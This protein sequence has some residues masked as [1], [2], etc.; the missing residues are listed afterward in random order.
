MNTRAV[1]AL[2]ALLAVAVMQGI[3][4]IPSLPVF[5]DQDFDRDGLTNERE[6]TLG[7]NPFK[8]DTDGDGVG[9]WLEVST[10]G[11]SPTRADTDGD[12]FSDSV[13][14]AGKPP[15]ADADPLQRDVF[16]EIDYMTG[17]KPSRE[18]LDRIA[19]V[20][21]DGPIRNP[22]GTTGIDIHFVIDEE[23]G[24][25]TGTTAED[26]TRIRKEHFDNSS[27]GYH[28]AV[29]ISE[30]GGQNTTR[31]GFQ[32]S[33]P[34]YRQMAIE[35][36]GGDFA[37][38]FMHE[39]GHSLG[40]DAEDYEGVDS[41]AVSANTYRSIMN[42][43]YADTP[44]RLSR[45][46]PFDDWDHINDSQINPTPRGLRSRITESVTELDRSNPDD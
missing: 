37:P 22:D 29:F 12:E 8:P 35:Y 28:Y 33:G 32:S 46:S 27:A 34:Q 11:T 45:G 42:Y 4:P 14:L 31:T 19:A 41:H 18:T 43:N 16:V 38:T 40:I 26:L 9:D 21:A 23:I 3:L 20:F 25:A 30:A 10:F 6:R 7:T 15:I 13:E 1:F 36:Q 24:Y 17:Q 39:L 44:L 2:V 5:P